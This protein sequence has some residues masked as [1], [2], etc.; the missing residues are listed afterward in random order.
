MR[1]KNPFEGKAHPVK[2]GP[3]EE[4][5]PA[6]NILLG[7]EEVQV[8]LL[9]LEK[10]HGRQDLLALYYVNTGIYYLALLILTLV[11]DPNSLGINRLTPAAIAA[12]MTTAC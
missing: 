6:D 8:I 11:S 9:D 7:L 12:S 4:S 10:R 5:S 1:N 2:E 3:S